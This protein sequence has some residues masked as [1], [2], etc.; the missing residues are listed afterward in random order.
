MIAINFFKKKVCWC[1]IRKKPIIVRENVN[2]QEENK[3]TEEELKR[4]YT[5]V[6]I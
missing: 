1:F 6:L 5:Y 2:Y 4:G 3:F